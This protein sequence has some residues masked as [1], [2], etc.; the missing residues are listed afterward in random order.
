M[1]LK[2][3]AFRRRDFLRYVTCSRIF[4]ALCV[5]RRKE[6]TFPFMPSTV[7]CALLYIILLILTTTIWCRN[8][9]LYFADEKPRLRENT[10]L[11]SSQLLSGE[12]DSNSNLFL[13]KHSQGMGDYSCLG[14]VWGTILKESNFDLKKT[15]QQT[16]KI[17]EDKQ[18]SFLPTSVQSHFHSCLEGTV[19]IAPSAGS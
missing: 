12:K 11:V 8:Y 16:N 3:T 15:N 1:P 4:S 9:Y 10:K 13:P 7:L 5:G 6:I 14:R 2:V 18:W 17:G 19:P